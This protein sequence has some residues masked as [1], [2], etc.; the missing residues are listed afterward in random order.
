MQIFDDI[1]NL[2][3]TSM[4]SNP[5]A[6]YRSLYPKTKGGFSTLDEFGLESSLWSTSNT[7]IIQSLADLPTPVA[8]IITLAN[9]NFY[10][11]KGSINIGVNTISIGS[12]TLLSGIDPNNDKI[13]Y[14]G[15]SSFINVTNKDFIISN[16]TLTCGVVGSTVF[17]V[18]GSSSN[19]VLISN[20]LYTGCKGL[21]TISTIGTILFNNNTITLCDNGI[22]LSGTL[23]DL[24]F[25]GN[26]FKGNNNTTSSVFLNFNN[27][28]IIDSALISGNLFNAQSNE[29]VIKQGVTITINQF[30]NVTPNTFEG[31]GTYL[32]GFTIN[33]IGWTFYNNT[34]LLDTSAIGEMYMIGN[35][36]AT[37]ILLT[38]SYVKVAGTTS[39]GVLQQFTSPSSNRLTYIGKKQIQFKVTCYYSISSP[40]N[41][42]SIRV[43]IFKSGSLV[44]SSQSEIKVSSV[45][46]EFSG[47]SGCII[48]LTLNDY[49]EIF[50][51]DVTGTNML[52]VVGLYVT[53]SKV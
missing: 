43:A 26:I 21:G 23:N 41:N 34:N 19:K 42:N 18:T 4:P 49:I 37:N 5:N 52:T 16:L 15:S 44:T 25:T 6:G 28:L 36:T 14:T 45:N 53:L 40:A 9:N 50:I 2:V 10:L 20:C 33:D 51:Q 30:L 47:S 38:S 3:N 31:A 7:N 48:S 46:G 17:N 24:I 32:S 22:T 35:A 11:I 27:N 39:S 13:I 8:G 1:V 29:T 12:S